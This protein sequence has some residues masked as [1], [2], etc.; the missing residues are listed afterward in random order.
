MSEHQPESL[1]DIAVR[2]ASH[3]SSTPLLLTLGDDGGGLRVYTYG[4]VLEAATRLAGALG[5]AGVGPGDRVGCY[6]PNSPSWVVASFA[7]WLRGAA[8]AAVGTLLPGLEASAS[9]R[10]GRDQSRGRR[11]GSAPRSRRARR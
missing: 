5:A 6:L 11:S 3:D 1:L 10:V 9:L 8:A 7:V 4:E 2:R